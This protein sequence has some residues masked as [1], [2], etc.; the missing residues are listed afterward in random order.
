MR[1]SEI[2]RKWRESIDPTSFPHEIR[3]RCKSCNRVG[4]CRWTSSYSYAGV[5]EYRSSCIACSREKDRV[6]RR[7]RQHKASLTVKIRKSRIKDRC[8]KYL[9]GACEDCG[10]A[11]CLRAMTFHHRDSSSKEKELSQILDWS[12]NKIVQELDKCVLLCF[13]CHMERHCREAK[14]YFGLCGHPE[15]S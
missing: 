9:G 12:W 2:R 4:M 5:P 11:K 15:G 13:N 3:K 14:S 6:V 10:Y 7:R 8:V 1:R